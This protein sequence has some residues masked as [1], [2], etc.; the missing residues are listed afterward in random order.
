M[1]AWQ[2][3]GGVVINKSIYTR[4]RVGPLGGD[5][6]VRRSGRVGDG[7]SGRVLA[8]GDFDGGVVVVVVVV[9]VETQ[10]S[11][12]DGGHYVGVGIVAGVVFVGGRGL[13]AT[14]RSV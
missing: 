11:L 9:V 8:V 14:R 3:S 4:T 1:V 5:T 10:E 12:G 13:R 7:R 2:S 6:G